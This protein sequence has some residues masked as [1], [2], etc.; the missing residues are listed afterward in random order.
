M[1]LMTT[2]GFLSVVQKPGDTDVLTV[3]AREKGHIEAAFPKAKVVTG[4]GTDYLY[5]ARVPRAEVAKVMHDQIM[6]IGYDNFKNAVP[7]DDLHDAY[8]GCWS[9]MMRYQMRAKK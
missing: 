4:Q 9:V 1:W 2:K 8:A 5:R 3:R 7:D 6:G